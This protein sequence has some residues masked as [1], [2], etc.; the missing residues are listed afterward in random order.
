MAAEVLNQD[1]I[2]ALLHGVD[3]GKV[4][5]QPVASE[6]E[7]RGYDFA[8]QSQSTISR[9]PAL[10][11]INERF[12]RQLRTSLLAMLRRPPE[13]SIPPMQTLR[14]ADYLPTLPTP[15]S[16]NLV[17]VAPLPGNAVVVLEPKLVF[18]VIDNF[19]GGMGREVK[20]EGREFTATENQI[21]R[22]LLTQIFAGMKDAWAPV[23][24]LEMTQIKAESN[25]QFA[26]FMSPAESVLVIRYHVEL[27]GGG[28]DI[29][30]AL[31]M[32]LLEPVQE[33]LR[34]GLQLVPA[35]HDDSWAQTLRNEL[36]ETE[37]DLVTVLCQAKVTLGEL[38]DLKPGD[39]VPCNFDGRATV[40]ADGMPLLQGE[41]GQQR[42]RQVVKVAQ[43]VGRKTG[44]TLDALVRR[45]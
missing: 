21:I 15:A 25:P 38:L 7:A 35:E 5:V 14:Y 1:E 41:L 42:G 26:T 17:K 6:G 12:A 22:M 37:I 39:V 13:I 33:L 3:S 2:D 19:F 40:L 10:E 8:A 44:N 36:E 30:V 34:A 9:M 20:I 24:A 23:L 43:L 45:V 27:P 32:P 11:M 28:G 31:P 18:A 29:H 16:I 4:D